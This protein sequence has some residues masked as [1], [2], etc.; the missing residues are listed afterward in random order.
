MRAAFAL[1]PDPN[2]LRVV[3]FLTDGYIGDDQEI[4][5]QIGGVLG[6]ARIYTVGIGSSVNRYLLDRMADLGR[7]AFVALRADENTDD[8]LEAFRSWVTMPYLTD[9]VVDW[10]SLPIADVTPER[11]RD[12]GS[13]QTLTLV[14]RYLFGGA[15]DV[16]V[17]GRLGGRYWEQRLRVTLPERETRHESL[18]SLWARSRIEELMLIQPGNVPESVRAE[19]TS[20]ALSYRLMSPFTSFVAVDDSVVVNSGGPSITVHQAL[21]V[22]DGVSFEGVFGSAGPAA[23]RDAGLQAATGTSAPA[24]GGLRVRVIDAADKSAVIGA[25]VTLSNT[26]K[27]VATSSI[28]T[29]QDGIAVF[30]WPRNGGGYVIT[31]IM[32]GYAGIRQDAQVSGN[33]TKEWV[34]A[35]APVHVERV[36]VMG[37]KSQVDLDENQASAK[38]SSDFIQD[39][40]VAGRFYQNVLG[41]APGASPAPPR[42]ISKAADGDG[43]PNVNGAR[44]R[45]FKTSVGGISSVDPLAGQFLNRVASDSIED[46]TVTSGATAV[47]DDLVRDAALRVLADLA[48]D[49]K[50]SRAEGRP[51]LAALLGAQVNSG[52]VSR[53]VI[54][55]ALATW[56]LDEAAQALPKDT[57]VS[58]A[59][60]KAVD[61]LAGLAT[62]GGWPA[63]AGQ[64][65][66]PEATRWGRLVMGMIRPS[67]VASIPM[68]AGQPS[69]QY[70]RLREA[71]AAAKS[72]QPPAP[73]KGRDPFDRLVASIGRGKLRS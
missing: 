8:A 72:G 30:P 14:G 25:S 2:R 15:G 41:L 19:V 64:S 4:L 12:L 35:L 66:D 26:N 10:G 44:E 34:I 57:W 63:S 17:R 28:M 13:G 36:T 47:R 52:A 5:S 67:V 56:A 70:K 55:H 31:A 24:A 6:D 27:L 43:N 49:G 39:L 51:A 29:D 18:A 50:L 40:P 60:A 62:P 32:D 42:S 11:I 65:M 20:L 16:V 37:E 45:D 48:D 59:R 21:P 73:A 46:L 7:G 22:P 53:D 54:A 71:I 9:L 68:P 69:P 58:A 3:I 61:Y 1:P 38:F 33:N 23:L